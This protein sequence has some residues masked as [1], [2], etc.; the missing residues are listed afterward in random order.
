MDGKRIDWLARMLARGSD[1]RG[2]LKTIAAGTLGGAA[3]VQ[4]TAADVGAQ[5][6]PGEDW[7]KLYEALAAAV[8]PVT[9]ECS[10][11]S[12]A[13]QQFHAQ[14]ADQIARMQADIATWSTDQVKAHQQAHG[15]RVQQAAV[16]IHLATSRCGYV[17]GSDSPLCL[18]DTQAT[19][20]DPMPAPGLGTPVAGK[21]FTA[22]I[23]EQCWSDPANP[24][25]Y[26]DC[27]C[28]SDFTVGNCI[29]WGAACVFGGCASPPNCCWA[30]ICVAGFSHDQCVAQC[31]NCVTIGND[32]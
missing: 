31:G 21:S 9:G 29:A 17:D 18:A 2:A 12:D 23:D 7:V 11:V 1:R 22:Q 24:G 13:V 16:A 25:A 30:G 32:C 5:D 3:L 28:N 15:A 8:D 26:C 19:V 27:A 14:N 10:Q 20:G 6:A 4:A